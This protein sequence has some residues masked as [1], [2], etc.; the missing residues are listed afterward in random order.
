[1]YIRYVS[2]VKLFIIIIVIE[3]S[4]IYPIQSFRLNNDFEI[5]IVMKPINI[6]FSKNTSFEFT[7]TGNSIFRGLQ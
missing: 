3:K 7:G 5:Q 6:L 2:F 1:M 4:I